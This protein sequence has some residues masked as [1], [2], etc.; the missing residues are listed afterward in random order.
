MENR[1]NTLKMLTAWALA[2]PLAARLAPAAA[3]A[4]PAGAGAEGFVLVNGWELT[5]ADL[6]ALRI[7]AL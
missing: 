2:L 4:T 1:R 5:R 3:A 6:D 7:D